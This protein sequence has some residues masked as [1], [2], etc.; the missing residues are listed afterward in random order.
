MPGGRGAGHA[1]RLVS[2]VEDPALRLLIHLVPV[3]AL[4]PCWLPPRPG[5][6][7]RGGLGAGGQ[8]SGRRDVRKHLDHSLHS[9]PEQRLLLNFTLFSSSHE[10]G[11]AGR[12]PRTCPPPRRRLGSR[13]QGCRRARDPV[14]RPGGPGARAGCSQAR[15]WLG[16]SL[17][18]QASSE[19]LATACQA[20]LG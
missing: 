16:S 10:A 3:T 9:C 19:L 8:R 12:K 18:P 6:V 2:P 13:S 14:A 5:S 4:R 1:A 20:P 17:P 7:P 11:A 15:A